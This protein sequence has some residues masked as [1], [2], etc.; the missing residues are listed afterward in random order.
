MFFAPFL[1]Q[2]I[3]FNRLTNFFIFL[4]HF[5]LQLITLCHMDN[6]NDDLITLRVPKKLK[7]DLK[8]KAKK[9]D[10]SL[11]SYIKLILYKLVGKG[12]K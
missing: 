6:K 4:L 10:R 11:S 9:Q 3:C 5:V 7:A 12:V 2:L 8:K 1:F